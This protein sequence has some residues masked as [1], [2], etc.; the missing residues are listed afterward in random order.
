MTTPL[1]VLDCGHGPTP[2]SSPG[3]GIAVDSK[4]G[5]EMCYACGD[6]RERGRIET[7]DEFV[8]YVNE[9]RRVITTWPGGELAKIRHLHT[10][11]VQYTPS[12]GRYRMR[13]VEAVTPDGVHW[14][15]KGGDGM[16]VI[17]MR[18]VKA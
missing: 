3:T 10:G 17:T 13:T 1:R 7:V 8:G 15:G 11:A 4:T 5:E 18:R 6:E 2:N 16:D 12:G 14:R 9:E